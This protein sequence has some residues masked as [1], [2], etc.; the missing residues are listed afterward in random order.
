[1]GEIGYVSARANA[2][3]DEVLFSALCSSL[4]EK[5][6]FAIVRYIGTSKGHPLKVGLLMPRSTPTTQYLI[7]VQVSSPIA[8]FFFQHG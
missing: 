1:M 8:V 7:F 6:R 5:G 3:T 2:P 4:E